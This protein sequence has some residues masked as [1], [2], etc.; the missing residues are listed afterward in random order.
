MEINSKIE[1]KN[2][3]GVHLRLS[4]NG[5]LGGNK[6]C[7]V[8][9]IGNRCSMENSLKESGINSR[10]NNK[11]FVIPVLSRVHDSGMFARG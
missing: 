4:S 7:F 5:S 11:T 1:T 8:C 3:I 9:S 2:C 6:V 10:G